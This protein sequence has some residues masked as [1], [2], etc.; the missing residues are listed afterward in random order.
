MDITADNVMARIREYRKQAGITRFRFACLAGVPEGSVR[1]IDDPSWN[2]TFSTFR[3]LDAVVPRDFV[4]KEA[5][6]NR[7]VKKKL[8]ISTALSHGAIRS[9]I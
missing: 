1:N 8:T 7:K 5:L 4:L 3:L 9:Q 2:P 6:A